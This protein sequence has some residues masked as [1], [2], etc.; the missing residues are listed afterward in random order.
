LDQVA[1][2]KCSS[3]DLDQVTRLERASFKFPYDRSTFLHFLQSS[4]S[5]F[6]VCE[7]EGKIVGYVVCSVM[8]ESSAT[9]VSIAVSSE[10]RRKGVGSL[11]LQAALANLPSGVR[12][13]DLQ[14]AKS[15]SGAINFYGHHGFEVKGTVPGYYE[16]GED[17]LL[18]SKI[19]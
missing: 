2:R 1:V 5:S 4:S 16:D 11:L 7:A 3:E 12:R 6:L 13:V 10:H 8:G 17:A 14:V 9:L 18:M 15:N 19:L